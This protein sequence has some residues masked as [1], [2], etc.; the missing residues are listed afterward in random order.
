MSE[1]DPILSDPIKRGL[2]AERILTSPVWVD[3]WSRMESQIVE[4]WKGETAINPD[5]MAELK[6]THMVLVKLRQHFE[7]A[8]ADGRI[9]RANQEKTLRQ[10]AAEFIGF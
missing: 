10:R 2:E 8:M 9:E 1:I 4:A 6:R 5:R 3:V 7:S